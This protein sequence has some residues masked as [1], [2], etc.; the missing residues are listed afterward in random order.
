MDF[1]ALL[2][3]IN[4]ARMYAGPGSEPMLAAASAWDG[5]AAELLL[6]AT[7]YRTVIDGLTGQQWMGPASAAMAAAAAPYATWMSTTAAQAEQTAAQAKAAAGAYEAAF[8]MTVPPPVIAANR[9]QLAALVATN[10]LGQNTPAIAATEAHYGE[11]WAQDAAAMYGYAAHSAAASQVTPFTG[12]QQNTNSARL[13]AHGAAVTQAGGASTQTQLS[14]LIS[15]VPST[16]QGLASPAAAGSDSGLAGIL[17]PLGVQPGDVL[18]AGTNLMSSS[19]SPMG[20]AG[21]TQVASDLAVV[22][23]AAIAAED[24]FGLG[25]LEAGLAPA[26]S[27]SGIAALGPAGFGG[28]GAVSAG[29]GRA[30]QLGALSVP[31]T[32]TAATTGANSTVTSF[33]ASGWT[34]AVPD[35]E[36]GGMPGM[37]GMPMASSGGRGVGFAA[38]RYG[39]KPTVMAR[40][41]VA[42]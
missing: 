42:G 4:S 1:G 15:A 36:P 6:T 40:P 41:V 18:N 11:M 10:V 26:A 20:V 22:R 28:T 25:A 30:T 24:P 33:P 32:W 37:P 23:G 27:G 31:Q 21:L 7:A 13:V 34:G 5:L 35:V 19:F 16:L 8:A 14:Q 17:S 29:L 38:P 39:F 2:P 12:P 3:E 9:A